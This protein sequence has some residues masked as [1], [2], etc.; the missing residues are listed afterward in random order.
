[1]K[2]KPSYSLITEDSIQVSEPDLEIKNTALRTTDHNGNILIVKRR[3]NSFSKIPVTNIRIT[4]GM[5]V[6]QSQQTS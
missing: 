5:T 4:D 2:N 1:M 3:Q 6:R